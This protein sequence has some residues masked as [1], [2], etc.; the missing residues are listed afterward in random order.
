MLLGYHHGDRL[1]ANALQMN[2]A[3]EAAAEW[4]AT[5]HR[6]IRCGHIHTGKRYRP[7]W[8]R[9]EAPGVQLEYFQVLAGLEAYG[10]EAGYSSRRSMMAIQ[11]HPQFGEQVRYTITPEML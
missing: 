3:Q 5:A 9:D 6:Y 8:D 2:M 7:A 4:A 1:N 10:A 11:H